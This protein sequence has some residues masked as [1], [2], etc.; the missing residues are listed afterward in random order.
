MNLCTVDELGRLRAR[1]GLLHEL[2]I[3]KAVGG[4]CSARGC[5][6][7]VLGLATPSGLARRL[8][9]P[10][11]VARQFCRATRDGAVSLAHRQAWRGSSW[12]IQRRSHSLTTIG[13]S[14]LTNNRIYKN[15][16]YMT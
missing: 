6:K 2:C 5:W 16:D 12:A 14:F 7:N 9:A 8:A 1:K 10:A 4:C 15:I 11:V 13:G 3:D